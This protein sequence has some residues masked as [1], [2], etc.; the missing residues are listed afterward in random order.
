MLTSVSSM[1]SQALYYLISTV[2]C[3]FDSIFVLR[4]RILWPDIYSPEHPIASGWSLYTHPWLLRYQAY[5]PWYI[6]D[7]TKFIYY[8]L[9]R[10]SVIMIPEKPQTTS[11][12]PEASLP[13]KRQR[14]K[15]QKCPKYFCKLQSTELSFGFQESVLEM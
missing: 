6:I 9:V 2:T 7:L 15:E 10:K 3:N 11:K 13:S 5:I 4:M 14:T 1:L 12:W 8:L